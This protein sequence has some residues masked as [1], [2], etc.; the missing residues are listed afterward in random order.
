[1]RGLFIRYDGT[2]SKC[3]RCML[4]AESP[5]G[6]ARERNH[7][8]NAKAAFACC[9]SLARCGIDRPAGGR[10]WPPCPKGRVRGR[11]RYPRCAG[12]GE[13]LPG[14]TIG[15]FIADR[16]VGTCRGGNQI[17]RSILVLRKL[18]ARGFFALQFL[19]NEGCASNGKARRIRFVRSSGYEVPAS[20]IR[21]FFRALRPEQGSRVIPW[22]IYIALLPMVA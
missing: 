14:A 11:P 8:D 17:L 12:I 1:M 21:S 10:G 16:K 7:E 2:F 5:A 9:R 18:M 13:L 4:V 22:F 3:G 19:K 15:L 6:A 20:G